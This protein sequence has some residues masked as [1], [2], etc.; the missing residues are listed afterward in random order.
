MCLQSST[1]TWWGHCCIFYL[2]T[3]VSRLGKVFC[4]Q[5]V[6]GYFAART[7]WDKYSHPTLLRASWSPPGIL[8]PEAIGSPR[9]QLETSEASSL[10][11]PSCS[12]YSPELDRKSLLNNDDIRTIPLPQAKLCFGAS[13]MTSPP[14]GLEFPLLV[15]NGLL[16]WGQEGGKRNGNSSWMRDSGQWPFGLHAGCVCGEAAFHCGIGEMEEVVQDCITKFL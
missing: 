14:I 4:T 15:L 5:W 11:S 7:A 6:F 3:Y 13:E 9:S 16:R 10:L 2:F 12:G 8:S 1:I